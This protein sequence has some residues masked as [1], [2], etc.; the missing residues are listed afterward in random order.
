MEE[1]KSTDQA[2]PELPRLY[3]PAFNIPA[4]QAKV[5]RINRR[6]VKLGV[7]QITLRETGETQ[8]KSYTC[9]ATGR[10]IKYDAIEVEVLGLEVKVPG[11]EL[12]ACLTRVG[13]A[14]LV[15]TVPGKTAPDAYVSSVPACEHC[16]KA[17]LRKETFVLRE[18]STGRHIQIGRNC[19]KDFLGHGSPESFLWYAYV[20]RDLEGGMSEGFS[21]VRGYESWA[22]ETVLEIAA[23]S[24][25]KFGWVSRKMAE[26]NECAHD[27][28]RSLVSTLLTPAVTEA[29]KDNR[30]EILRKAGQDGYSLKI[31]TTEE[32]RANAANAIEWAASLTREQISGNNYLANLH[33]IAGFGF[34]D[35]KSL[36]IAVSIFVARDNAADRERVRSE[37]EVA[38]MAKREKDMES[39]HIG[40]V[41]KR[42]EMLL[43]LERQIDLGPSQFCEHRRLL[44]FRDADGNIAVWFT[45]APAEVTDGEKYLVKATVKKHDEFKGVKQTVLS[46]V[47]FLEKTSCISQ[48]KGA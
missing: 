30:R 6:A 40:E 42:S 37:Q 46:R 16:K 3:V 18:E 5:D 7:P 24:I 10:S 17:R 2:K 27:T 35:E 25:R 47:S 45:G 20:I 22:L 43:T 29:E 11:W 19:I 1:A 36:G 15:M 33:T 31:E 23:W 41:G 4:L 12:V 32:D 48:E 39:K 26:Q 14:N 28:T 21:G 13:E 8:K 34:A 38:R 9:R 44:R